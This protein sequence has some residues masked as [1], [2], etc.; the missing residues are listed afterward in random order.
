MDKRDI[1][2]IRGFRQEGRYVFSQQVWISIADPRLERF[3][4][5]TEVQIAIHIQNGAR[6]IVGQVAQHAFAFDQRIIETVH[7]LY[8]C[9]LGEDDEQC[10]LGIQNGKIRDA[11]PLLLTRRI[12][13]QPCEGAGGAVGQHVVK[14]RSCRFQFGR[15]HEV[16]EAFADHC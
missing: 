2:F 4:H 11:N 5:V 16:V 6:S 12:F 13:P 9:D 10:T 14:M 15:C 8:L 7:I 3:V 1:K